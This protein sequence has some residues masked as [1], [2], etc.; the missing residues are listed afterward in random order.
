MINITNAN[1]DLRTKED[2][3][4]LIGFKVMI[5]S[6]FLSVLLYT[7]VDINSDTNKN[8]TE[9]LIFISLSNKVYFSKIIFDFFNINF[10]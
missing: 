4:D 5:V 8:F 6:F 9:I 2:R 10:G 7:C 1:L 3:V